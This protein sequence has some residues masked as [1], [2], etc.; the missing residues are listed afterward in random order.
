[1][2]TSTYD[3]VI[4]GGGTA[5]CALAAR[6][7]QGDASK[8]VA[9]LERG[10]DARAHP[11]VTNPL[12][13]GLLPTTDLV[14]THKTE[15]Q[16][17]LG[18]RSLNNLAG[19]LLSGS[20]GINY[21]A[22]YRG[23]SVDYDNWA[24]LVNDDRW[25]YEKL[26]PYFRMTETHYDINGDP[27]HHGFN[28][29]I[30]SSS[31]RKYPLSE[32]MRAAY[33]SQGY[34]ELIDVNN[35]SP[36]G[37]GPYVENWYQYKRQPSGSAYD[38]SGVNVLCDTPVH[39]VIFKQSANDGGKH[40]AEAVQLQSG[41]TIAAGKEIIISAGALRTPQ[42][43]MLSGIGPGDQI[44]QKFG[45]DHLVDLPDVGRNLFDHFS[46]FQIFRLHDS[47]SDKGYAFGSS[48]WTKEEYSEGFPMDWI[49]RSQVPRD[50]L[51]AA[52][53]ADARPGDQVP[54]AHPLLSL[55]CAHFNTL[56]IYIPIGVSHGYDA[57]PNGQHITLS[58]LLYHPT[59]RGTITLPSADPS[60]DPII[61]PNYYSTHADR[62]TLRHAIRRLL[63]LAESESL[64]PFLAGEQPPTGWPAL[65][66]KSTDEE[67]DRRV[68]E[69][70]EVWNHPAGT[71]AMGK[72][73]DAEL[74]VYG[75]EGLRVV[76]AS[77]FPGT[78]GAT[79]QQTVYT[80]AE[81]VAGLILGE[82]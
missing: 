67:I 46:L 79:L 75:T 27:K 33:L 19:R 70:G 7:K 32:P 17:S 49:A 81:R 18:G 36:L 30:H 82:K 4:I 77:V 25:T 42:I 54:D 20:S 1:M 58:T 9:L 45:L 13:A 41:R 6:L 52:L 73:V 26:L 15:T 23:A 16:A 71:A 35:G 38:L 55:K 50:G 2:E 59:S 28:G 66:S 14:S 5:G 51:K 60:A 39:R 11:Y 12:A 74:R 53:E 65:S 56:G 31:G 78:V 43:L 22:W 34:K 3:Y 8:S 72:V 68:R 10:P 62:H 64:R 29:P 40:R 21:G 57:P 63:A 48:G 76:D 69:F 24:M 44:R 47:F 80:V 37:V 61:N